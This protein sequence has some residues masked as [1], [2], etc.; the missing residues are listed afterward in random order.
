[1]ERVRHQPEG[2]AAEG[3]ERVPE[4]HGAEASVCLGEREPQ[5]T[6]SGRIRCCFPGQSIAAAAEQVPHRPADGFYPG[7]KLHPDHARK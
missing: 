3:F 5:Q 1:M 4:R 6:E 2:R 7:G